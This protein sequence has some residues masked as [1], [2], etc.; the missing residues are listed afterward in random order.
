MTESLVW[1]KS[2]AKLRGRFSLEA[3]LK[4]K[5]LLSWDEVSLTLRASLFARQRKRKCGWISSVINTQ[6]DV[7]NLCYYPLVMKATF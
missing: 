7:N 4:I 2:L 5:K 1:I 6:C 3:V